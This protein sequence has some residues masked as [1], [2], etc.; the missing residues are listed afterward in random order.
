MIKIYTGDKDSNRQIISIVVSIFSM[1]R[2]NTNTL[3][4]PISE[5]FNEKISLDI[6]N[7]K[8]KID[9]VVTKVSEILFDKF[10]SPEEKEEVR[11]K[12]I[13]KEDSPQNVKH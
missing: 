2:M 13:E 1:R 6:Q 3:N 4:I 10:L 5:I 11:K 7:L 12:R 8:N 9:V